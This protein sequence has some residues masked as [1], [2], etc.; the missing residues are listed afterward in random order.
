MRARRGEVRDVGRAKG[1]VRGE[2]VAQAPHGPVIGTRGDE[3][4]ARPG[5]SATN[6]EALIPVGALIGMIRARV[7]MAVT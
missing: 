6:A 2:L 4:P 1:P 7:V 5:A 3:G